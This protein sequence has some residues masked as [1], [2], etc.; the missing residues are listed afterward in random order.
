MGPLPA[1]AAAIS[2][3]PADVPF[4]DAL[5]AGLRAE[6]GGDPLAL[7]RYTILLPTRRAGRALAEAFL[8]SSEGRALLLPRLVPVGDVDAEELAFAADEGGDAPSFDIPPAVPELERLLLLTRLALEWGRR[9]GGGPLTAVQ[10]AP[11]ARELS[12]FLDEVQ[13][14]GGDF[15]RLGDLVPADYAEH[16][17]QVL[18]FLGIVTAYWPR[19]LAERGYLDP[20]ERRNRVLRAQ[21][22]ACRRAPPSDPVIAAGLAGGIAAVVELLLTVA[23][24]PCGRIVL[25]G[26]SRETDRESW[27]AVSADPAHPQHLM[28]QLLRRLEIEPA[29]VR[30]WPHLPPA[31]DHRARRRLVA[32]ALRPAAESDRW[33]GIAGVGAAALGGLMRLDCDGAQ[34]EAVVIALLLR[35]A[36]DEEAATAALVTPDRDLARRVAAELRRWDID[37][38]DS[39][40]LP[41]A[42]TPPG[43]FLRLLLAAAAEALAPLPLLAAL[44]HPLAAGGRA[45]QAFRA[46]VRRLELA[47]LRGARPA[48]GFAGLRQALPASDPLQAFIATLETA[49][50][51]LLSAIAA[52]DAPLSE[53][54][55][56]H[57]AAAEALAASDAE[58][59][60]ERLWREEAGEAAAL[61]IA[62]LLATADAFP[63][64]AGRDYPPL[65]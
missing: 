63:T 30:D 55:A 5:V 20:A 58:A 12:R 15:S 29:A 57:I 61:F 17:Q 33:R 48:P 36:L 32:E 53:L 38:D 18:E 47:A 1:A 10:A 62:E 16:W 45:P 8:R 35:R 54:V 60:P 25:A 4:F 14:E 7:A 39:A 19:H 31:P 34:E 13:T 24:L 27:S 42:R 26:L 37:I 28:A 51:P 46:L 50:A 56:A 22:E 44:K 3:I 49:V 11:L 41:L 23:A 2:T 52:P 59:G 21:A 9:R 64:L 65:F 40:G 6:S 43:V